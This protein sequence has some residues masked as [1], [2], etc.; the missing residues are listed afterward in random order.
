M[1]R[2]FRVIALIAVAIVLL[3]AFACWRGCGRNRDALTKYKAE[4]REKGEKL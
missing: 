1:N 4:L 3:V 2:P